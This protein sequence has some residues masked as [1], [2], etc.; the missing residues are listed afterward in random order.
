MD[1]E[2]TGR[3]ERKLRRAGAEDLII[4]MTNG[5]SAPAPARGEILGENASLSLALEYRGHWV[6]IARCLP[7]LAVERANTTFELLSGPYPYEPVENAGLLPDGAIAAVRREFRRGDARLFHGD[8]YLY[9]H[10]QLTILS[11]E[12]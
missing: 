11:G 6:K 5:E 3:L 9:H 7:R 12:H 4:L 1:Y 10:G 8:T 2:F